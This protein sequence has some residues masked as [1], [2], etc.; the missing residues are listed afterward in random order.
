MGLIDANELK[1]HIKEHV[2]RVSDHEGGEVLIIKNNNIEKLIDEMPVA[3]DVDKVCKEIYSVY[4]L[5]FND[6]I[7]IYYE[8]ENCIG[9]SCDRCMY[10]EMIKIVKQGGH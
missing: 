3:Y 9:E 6:H 7:C 4:D 8:N 10:E 5:S 1:K 2:I